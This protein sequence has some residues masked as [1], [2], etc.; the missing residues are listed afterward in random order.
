MMPCG[1]ARTFH[2]SVEAGARATS[3][4]EQVMLFDGITTKWIPAR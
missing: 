3:A 4:S 1:G 2:L